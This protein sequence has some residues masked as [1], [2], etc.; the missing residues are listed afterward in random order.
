MLPSQHALH[1]SDSFAI[2]KPDAQRWSPTGLPSGS[3][4]LC[5]PSQLGAIISGYNHAILFLC[6]VYL[7]IV[8]KFLVLIT[9][10]S[11][12]SCT[13]IQFCTTDGA[14]FVLL[15]CCDNK[16][17]LCYFGSATHI[18]HKVNTHFQMWNVYLEWLTLHQRGRS[19]H[20]YSPG[21][22]FCVFSMQR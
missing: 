16:N 7:F 3:S 9:Y 2:L 11:L 17:L 13:F 10:S 8:C 4:A 6:C 15:Y 5:L 18:W 22:H 20:G 1:I 14:T 12:L 19:S 21:C